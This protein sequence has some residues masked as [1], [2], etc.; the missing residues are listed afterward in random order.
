MKKTK[1]V[2][3]SLKQCA[4]A[5][6]ISVESL[7]ELKALGCPAFRGSRVHWNE[8]V[9]WL[10][11]HPSNKIKQRVK[12]N[13]PEDELTARVLSLEWNTASLYCFLTLE[14][15]GKR[16]H[17]EAAAK[18]V[19]NSVISATGELRELLKRY[20]AEFPEFQPQPE[21]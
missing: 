8:L 12:A 2:Y 16:P 4:G 3:D 5:E 19:R 1:E 13:T 15:H 14:E 20:P 17:F 7:Q 18:L 21:E 11:K 10:T 6:E 9:R